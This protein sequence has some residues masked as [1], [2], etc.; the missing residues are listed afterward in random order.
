MMDFLQKPKSVLKKNLSKAPTSSVIQ[1]SEG[2][3]DG[4]PAGRLRGNSRMKLGDADGELAPRSSSD[5]ARD[6]LVCLPLSHVS[7]A[8]FTS[9]Q[10]L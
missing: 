6:P 10:L 3:G 7:D 4:E 1:D 5:G 9:M 2:V 8:L